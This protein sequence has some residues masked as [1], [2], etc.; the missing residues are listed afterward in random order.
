MLNKATVKDQIIEA[1]RD[2][3]GLTDT[4]L[5]KRLGKRHQYINAACNE[6]SR[7]RIIERRKDGASGPFRN[8][9]I[10]GGAVTHENE[11]EIK[12]SDRR[13]GVQ[14]EGK[15]YHQ[16]ASGD[17]NSQFRFEEFASELYLTVKLVSAIL[18]KP[19][20]TQ[21]I[22]AIDRGMPHEPQSLVKG[23]M[24]VYMFMYNGR[25]L[26]IGKAGPN[27]NARYSSQHYNPKSS[28]SNLSASILADPEMKGLGITEDNVGQWIMRNCRR[29]DIRMNSSLGIFAL[30]L[31][32]SMLHY[33][34]DPKYEGYQAQRK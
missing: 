23:T 18:G 15:S 8:Y 16:H 14:P 11:P 32:E 28:G 17:N 30:E 27:S 21:G 33:K 34:Y 12:C 26:K 2:S 5:E 29:I 9:P 7:N 13:L 6:L 1:L 31:V 19:I 3:P 22:E 10:A 25:F 24:S 4:E 20:D